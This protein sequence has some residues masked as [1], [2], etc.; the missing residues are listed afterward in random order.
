MNKTKRVPTCSRFPQI[1]PPPP[2]LNEG[3]KEHR[4]CR[5]CLPDPWGMSLSRAKLR[6]A[7]WNWL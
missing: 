4:L 7:D 1:P 3:N 5:A 6:K 2:P